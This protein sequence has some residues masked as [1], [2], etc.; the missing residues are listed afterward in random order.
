MLAVSN[1]FKH[2][3]K[4]KVIS[5]A[6]LHGVEAEILEFEVNENSKITKKRIKD[7]KFPKSAIIGGVVRNGKGLMTMGDFLLL[8]KD[9]AVVFCLPNA[10]HEVE[11]FF[12]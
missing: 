4:G 11:S 1:I 10:I 5:I 3:R 6:N 8:P 2:I 9:R 12:K 7:L